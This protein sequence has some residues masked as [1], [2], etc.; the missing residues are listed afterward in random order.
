MPEMVEVG[1]RLA[2]RE[3]ALLQIELTVEEHWDEFGCRVW[4][5]RRG[6]QLGQT[7]F[8]M[9]AQLIDARTCADK[10][11]TVRRKD[12]RI[13]REVGK[14]SQRIE[15]PRQRIA[16]GLDRPDADIGADPWQ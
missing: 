15:K 10:G 12:E 5:I 9:R 4:L 14:R 7:R 13:W 8:M 3:K 6:N 16:V 2:H 11:Q 1:D